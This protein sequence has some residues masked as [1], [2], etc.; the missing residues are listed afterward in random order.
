MNPQW[1]VYLQ[2]AQQMQLLLEVV[3]RML[4]VL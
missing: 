4:D 2:W 1:L 3:I